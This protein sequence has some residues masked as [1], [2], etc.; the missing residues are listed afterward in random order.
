M[1]YS[2]ENRFVDIF[3]REDYSD[4]CKFSLD[5]LQ[6]L[7]R[8][9]KKSQKDIIK[10]K[11]NGLMKT[12]YA[13]SIYLQLL[14]E[15]KPK[16][17]IEFGTWQG[18][19]AHWFYDMCKAVEVTPK[20]YTFSDENHIISPL[21][22][23]IEFFIMDNYKVSEYEIPFKTVEHPL[24]VVEDSHRNY[25]EVLNKFNHL[26]EVGDYLVIEDTHY[27]LIGEKTN[28][29]YNDEMKKYVHENNF[30]VDTKFCDMFGYN[31]TDCVN[32]IL[33]KF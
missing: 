26:F 2:E 21:P 33:K 24:L 28:Q 23:D 6:Y 31:L 15:L 13:I 16:T 7:S 19:S 25:L 20:V 3:D 5:N 17:I 10:W 12:H 30:M 27:D 32:S 14:Q 9:I 22:E 11:G 8:Y 18:G 4:F 29:K 1:N